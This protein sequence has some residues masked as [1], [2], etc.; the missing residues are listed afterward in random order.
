MLH[1]TRVSDGSFVMRR[2][3]RGGRWVIG[4]S[5]DSE[6]QLNDNGVSRTHAE[7]K[8]CP[9]GRW[10]IHDMGS[11]NG[12]LVNGCRVR[13]QIL[14]HGDRLVVGP[15]QLS[16]DTPEVEAPKES[17]SP[18]ALRHSSEPSPDWRVA[19]LDNVTAL[20]RSLMRTE[21]A[22]A[23]RQELAERMVVRFGARAALVLRLYP[24]GRMRLLAGPCGDGATAPVSEKVL[25]ALLN[26][27]WLDAPRE[28]DKSTLPGLFA[29]PGLMA[30]PIHE[31]AGRMD[32]L[33]VSVADVH[34]TQE[35]WA[36][37]Q[38]CASTFQQSE[39]VWKMKQK[40]RSSAFV[41]H[42]LETARSVQHRL[43]P[44]DAH[45]DHLE[46]V[47]GYEPSMRVGG[48]YVDALALPGGRVLFVIADVC[49]KGMQ[50][51]LVT[52]SLHTLIRATVE[53]GE[54]LPRLVSQMNRYLTRHLPED[55]FVTLA[56]VA[57][58]PKS[59]LIECVNAGHPPVL[60]ARPDG[61]VRALQCA[62]NLALGMLDDASFAPEYSQLLE[63]EV[64]LMYTDGLVELLDAN[65]R[66]LG[67]ER[68]RSGVGRTVAQ[69]GGAPV[70]ALETALRAMIDDHR[71]AH[72][73]VDDAAFLIARRSVAASTLRWNNENICRRTIH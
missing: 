48:D 71:R 16:V 72:L 15:F 6:I 46:T 13:S 66:P 64:L 2:E 58:D 7:L 49:G 55:S 50:G 70:K 60:I 27:E 24:N 3:L 26:H 61:D 10:W 56:A 51:A 22:A 20:G 23:R 54:P 8:R 63:D 28:G 39:L 73:A 44:L 32:A 12:T 67:M 25:R 59:G 41:E 19:H 1:V 17:S 11:T 5:S 38:L 21:G 36:L 33:Y 30:C 65:R 47:L 57:L 40:V 37:L 4:R 68:F 62:S 18:G 34:A 52:S 43:I 14:S 31:S 35:W 45:F 29:A 69:S 53:R 42:E 9:F